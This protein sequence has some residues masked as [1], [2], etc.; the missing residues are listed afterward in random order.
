MA[1]H[2]T[3]EYFGVQ[4]LCPTQWLQSCCNRVAAKQAPDHHLTALFLAHGRCLCWYAVFLFLYFFYKYWCC[5]IANIPTLVLS[6]LVLSKDCR[7]NVISY[8]DMFF[9]NCTV[10]HFNT[11]HANWG[12]FSPTC[13]SSVFCSFSEP[14]WDPVQSRGSPC[15]NMLRKRLIWVLQV[16]LYLWVTMLKP[17]A[18]FQ[19]WSGVLFLTS[20]CHIW[21]FCH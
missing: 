11:W 19:Y 20:I 21:Y 2:L 14:V 15:S 5:I 4:S 13:S 3:L 18:V 1:S 6:W 16:Y 17:T 12:L 10:M 8:V 9:Y 7:S